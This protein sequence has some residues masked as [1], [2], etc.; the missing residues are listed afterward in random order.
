MGEIIQFR[1]KAEERRRIARELEAIWDL[2]DSLDD[3]S[4][5]L[6]NDLLRVA[7]AH[8]HRHRMSLDEAQRILTEA[9]P[10]PRDSI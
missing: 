6:F 4:N 5:P 1:S 10:P 8:L 3:S 7:E 9:W 2:I